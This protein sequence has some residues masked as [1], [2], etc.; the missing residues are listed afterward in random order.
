[1]KR[2]I[3]SS[4]GYIT[5][6]QATIGSGLRRLYHSQ[7]F[8]AFVTTVLGEKSLYPYAD[9]LSSI[10]VN[11]AHDGQELGRHFENSSFAI[12]LLS[13][14][15]IVGVFE[16]MP[17][18]RDTAAEEMNFTGVAD[19][20]DGKTPVK[21]SEMQ[22]GTFLLFC[23]RNSLHGV[24]P[25]FGERTRLLVVLAYNDVPDVRLSEGNPMI[26]YGRV[27]TQ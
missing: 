12:P 26:F 22:S 13:Q 18:F 14:A 27:G 11:Y 15:P 24:T 1:M 25:T 8:Q 9:S 23:G 20:L 10:N 4:K 5:T 21:I 19:V 2:Q 3:K 16:Y 7:Q 6:D 17:N